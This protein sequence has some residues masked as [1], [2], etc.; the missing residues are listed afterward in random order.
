MFSYVFSY[1]NLFTSKIRKKSEKKATA[2]ILVFISA[3]YY[4]SCALVY[5]TVFGVS[6]VVRLLGSRPVLPSIGSG[7]LR[8]VSP[9]NSRLFPAF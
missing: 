9:T 4:F 8:N 6:R 2:T 5:L 3:I 1:S 7:C